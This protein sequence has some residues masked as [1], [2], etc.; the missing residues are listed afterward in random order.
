MVP[1]GRKKKPRGNDSHF[2]DIRGSII[3]DGDE[4]IQSKMKYFSKN[5][6]FLTFF[7]GEAKAVERKEKKALLFSGKWC[8]LFRKLWGN[9][10]SKDAGVMEW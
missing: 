5:P 3:Q 7:F 4:I 1:S 8:I 2:I 9:P 10:G 6:T